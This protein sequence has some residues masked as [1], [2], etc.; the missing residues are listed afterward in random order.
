VNS[1]SRP[2]RVEITTV[3]PSQMKALKRQAAERAAREQAE[4]SEQSN[5]PQKED[6]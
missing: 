1:D 6:S 2:G 3:G 5:E 4:Q